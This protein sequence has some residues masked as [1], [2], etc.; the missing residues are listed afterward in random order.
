VWAKNLTSDGTK[1]YSEAEAA[2]GG[3]G[4]MRG[5]DVLPMLVD[6]SR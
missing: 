2:S 3:L 5:V 1:T 4:H 6:L